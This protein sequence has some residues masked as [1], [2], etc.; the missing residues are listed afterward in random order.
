MSYV[1]PLLPNWKS[2]YSDDHSI[3]FAR[4]PAINPLN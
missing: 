4:I 2:V 1:L 3:V